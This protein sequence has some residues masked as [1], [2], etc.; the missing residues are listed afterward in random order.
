MSAVGPEEAFVDR[1]STTDS[2]KEDE[3]GMYLMY[4]RIRM[5]YK[6]RELLAG[7]GIEAEGRGAEDHTCEP[8]TVGFCR[9][10]EG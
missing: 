9:T 2:L 3:L 6:C 8:V 7:K 5:N 1:L 4:I 10:R